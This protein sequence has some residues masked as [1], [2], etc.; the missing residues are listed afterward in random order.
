MINFK[1]GACVDTRTEEQKQKD[2]EYIKT[3]QM[4]TVVILEELKKKKII[5]YFCTRFQAV[6][7]V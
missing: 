4:Q 5:L 2:I 1:N 3:T 6:L 7:S